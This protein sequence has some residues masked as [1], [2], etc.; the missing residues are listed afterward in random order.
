MS[1]YYFSTQQIFKYFFRNGLELMKMWIFLVSLQQ[2]HFLDIDIDCQVNFMSPGL[3]Y[4]C[5]LNQ[6]LP[7]KDIPKHQGQ[8]ICLC[9]FL[10]ALPCICL[11][12][13]CI[14]LLSLYLY[15][16]L[17]QCL[18]QIV[19]GCIIT[20]LCPPSLCRQYIQHSLLYSFLSLSLYLFLCCVYIYSNV[21]GTLLLAV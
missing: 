7:K 5:C 19:V 10:Y 4:I 18:V 12:C 11:F 17:Q 3:T 9:V 6:I 16:S 13:F 14:C 2:K 21:S 8:D 20:R 1:S 15:L